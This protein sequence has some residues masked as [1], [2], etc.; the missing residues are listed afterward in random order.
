MPDPF[1]NAFKKGALNPLVGGTEDDGDGEE[2]S[3][4]TVR[5]LTRYDT[6]QPGST[7]WNQYGPAAVKDCINPA[8][9]LSAVDTRAGESS[10]SGVTSQGA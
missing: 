3:D 2:D 1:P 8:L 6:V 9:L 7:R 5:P 10:S 4:S